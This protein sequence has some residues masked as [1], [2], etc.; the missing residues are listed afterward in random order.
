[1]DVDLRRLDHRLRELLLILILLTALEG[2]GAKPNQVIKLTTF[3]VNHDQ[4]KLGV[5]TK[6]VKETFAREKKT[7]HYGGLFNILLWNN[8]GKLVKRLATQAYRGYVG[9]EDLADLMRLYD[10]GR[11]KEDFEA[12]IRLAVQA[13]LAN[14]RFL[15]ELRVVSPLRARAG[16]S[17]TAR[18]RT[19]RCSA[20]TPEYSTGISQP[21]K[22]TNFAPALIK[23]LANFDIYSGEHI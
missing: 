20:V 8:N 15:F 21:P 19:A 9:G 5:L 1:M 11:G 14:P 6:N 16:A 7:D 23:R 2:I 18:V 4:S 13:I 10:Q 17:F 12:G 22:S 3:V